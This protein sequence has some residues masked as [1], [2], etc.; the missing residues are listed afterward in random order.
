MSDIDVIWNGKGTIPGMSGEGWSQRSNALL[1]AAPGS[2]DLITDAESHAMTKKLRALEA[3]TSTFNGRKPGRPATSGNQTT[4]CHCG[5]KKHRHSRICNG[6]RVGKK[7]RG[8]TRVGSPD[9]IRALPYRKGTD[10]S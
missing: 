5:R 9:V 2:K 6:C 7:Q 1:L 10:R 4:T 8:G 3:G